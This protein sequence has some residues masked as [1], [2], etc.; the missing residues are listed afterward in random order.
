MGGETTEARR[1]R[2]R[3][4]GYEPGKFSPGSQ[5][6]IMDVPGKALE[7]WLRIGVLVLIE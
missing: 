6:S 7:I 4:L 1:P 2:I 3:D 5:N